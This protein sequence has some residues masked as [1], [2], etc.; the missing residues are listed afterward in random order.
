MAKEENVKK[1]TT[2]GKENTTK[3][4]N[5]NGSKPKTTNTKSSATKK[6]EKKNNTSVKN[7][8]NEEKKA[9]QL[10]IEE[11][12][13]KE[14]KTNDKKK[15]NAKTNKVKVSDI[16]LLVGLVIVILV[17][18]LTM[19]GEKVKPS[20][21]LP[22]S[23]TGDAGLNLLSYEEYQSKID[24]KEQFVVVLSRESCSHCAN[25]LPVAKQFAE[26]KKL[27]MYYIDTDTFTEDNW[28]TFETSNTFLK[29]KKGSWGT[30]TTVVL[31]GSEAVDYIE[32]ETTAENLTEL[33]N[34]YFKTK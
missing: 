12:E 3:T 23:L 4:K 7:E 30:P 13:I 29:Q 26:D 5:T 17:G 22:L 11:V 14:V 9:K 2:K 28:K 8:K 15:D 1:N 18:L 32:G 19:K 24:N 31:A 6:N 10:S 33:Y 21:T 16:L 34:K 20:Y 27:P 25:F